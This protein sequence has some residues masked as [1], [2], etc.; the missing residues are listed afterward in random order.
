MSEFKYIFIHRYVYVFQKL[1]GILEKEQNISMWDFRFSRRRV[2]SSES[3]GIYCHVLKTLSNSIWDHGSA[4]QKTL[5]FKIFLDYLWLHKPL[6]L[7]EVRI[8]SQW[9]C[10]SSRFPCVKK[11]LL[12]ADS[13]GLMD[14][15][16]TGSIQLNKMVSLQTRRTLCCCWRYAN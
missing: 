4:S 13:M 6:W 1:N 8:M 7:Q 9:M 15:T 11:A 2:W 16:F 12:V 5:N 3:S 10:L 14:L